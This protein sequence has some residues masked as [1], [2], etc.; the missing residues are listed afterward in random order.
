[1]SWLPHISASGIAM[2]E[3]E[4]EAEGREI[5]FVWGGWVFQ[6]VLAKIDRRFDEERDD[7]AR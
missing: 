2:S 7:H 3:Q 1:M 6:I 4:F 5:Q